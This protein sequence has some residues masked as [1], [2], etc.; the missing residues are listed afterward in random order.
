MDTLWGIDMGGTKTEGVVIVRKTRT[1]IV[2][3]RI[4]TQS[5]MGYD[6]ILNRIDI[7]VKEMISQSGVVPDQI[8]FGTPG[9]L[10]PATGHI[11]NSNTTCLNGKPLQED[12]EKKLGVKVKIANDANC[13]TL[14]EY[15][16]GVIP[17]LSD[18]PGTVFG[19][20]LGTGVGGGIVVNGQVLY[21]HHGIG[22]EWGHNFLDASGGQCYCGKTG[23]VETIISGPALEKYYAGLTGEPRSLREIYQLYQSA[24]DPAAAETIERLLY[25]FGKAV[26]AVINIIDPSYVI[27]GGGVGNIAALYE[28]GAGY[29]K[30][31]IFNDRVSTKIVKPVLGDSA[32]VFGA[33]MLFG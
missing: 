8:G 24:E 4:E 33:A 28:K 14:A 2:R 3:K 32:G 21:G 1:V 19:I 20:I 29:I 5:E 18:D 22:G 31:F 25:F 12:L 26:A 9:T 15:H 7:L 16:M 30:P 10:D 23:C 27:I 17:T 13:L 6:H 11:K